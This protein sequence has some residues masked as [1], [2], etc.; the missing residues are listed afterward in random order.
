M[1]SIAEPAPTR[2][3]PLAPNTFERVLAIGATLL[4][5]AVIVALAKGYSEWGRV[6]W[7]VWPHLLTIM[8]AT[9]LTP[10]MLLRRRG[11]RPHRLL[12][13]IWVISMIATAALSFNLRLINHGGLSLIHILSAWTLIQAPVIW[14]SARTH[15]VTMHR[16]SV[17]YMVLGALLVAGFFTFP[18]NRLM[19]H[20]LFG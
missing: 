7:Q 6:P 8:L 14:W 3:N 17:R 10:V 4:L 12:G 16:R 11:D 2:I 19:G 5:V 13:T 9:A 1:V 18:F 15:R 20:W